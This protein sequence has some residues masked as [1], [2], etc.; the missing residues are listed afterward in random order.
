[1]TFSYNVIQVAA[2]LAVLAAIYLKIFLTETSRG[3]IDAAAVE[4]P[5]L[6]SV[7][8]QTSSEADKPELLKN[9]L[10]KI[11]LPKDVIRML[12]SSHTVSLASFVAFFNAIAEAG[13][14]SS[15]MVYIYNFSIH[16]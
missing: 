1:M 10:K 4:E 5:I 2:G 12:K 3:E 6:K 9:A 14:S 16:I 8:D 13:V 7:V 15:Q 11:P